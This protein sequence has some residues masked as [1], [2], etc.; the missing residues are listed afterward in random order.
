MNIDLNL[1]SEFANMTVPLWEKV[2]YFNLFEDWGDPYKMKVR[3]IYYLDSLRKYIHPHTLIIHCGVEERESGWHPTGVA[4]DMHSPTLSYKDL[5]YQAM[6]F[7]FTGIGLYPY[8]NNPGVH[9]DVRPMPKDCKRKVW[10]RDAA[11]EYH[12]INSLVDLMRL[13]L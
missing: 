6:Q 1:C 12:N 5:A 3:E 2:V 10:W 13:R 11:G 4:A 7:P 8:W 9:L